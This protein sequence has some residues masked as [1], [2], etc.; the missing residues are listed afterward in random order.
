MIIFKNEEAIDTGGGEFLRRNI[1]NSRHYTST[2]FF[3]LREQEESIC[4]MNLCYQ[5][6]QILLTYIILRLLLGE[7]S[8]EEIVWP[9]S[10]SRKK[11]P[12]PVSIRSYKKGHLI[13]KC[14]MYLTASILLHKIIPDFESFFQWM[15]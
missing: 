12:V 9:F 4:L 8:F 3:L 1:E 14:I 15:D 7:E 11:A 13:A 6:F 2:T 10:N 5:S